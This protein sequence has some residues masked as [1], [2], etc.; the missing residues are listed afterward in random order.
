MALTAQAVL[1]DDRPAVVGA[2]ELW[3]APVVLLFCG[4]L[5]LHAVAP[6]RDDAR[7]GDA[8]HPQAEAVAR[9]AAQRRRVAVLRPD[10]DGHGR[11]KCTT[12]TRVEI[13]GRGKTADEDDGVERRVADLGNLR[14]EEVEDLL[15]GSV[16]QSVSGSSR[17][18]R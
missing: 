11:A 10:N 5:A 7:H 13:L 9:R 17:T 8:A 3:P 12:D 2:D 1:A 4:Q 6:R 16:E 18:G 14:R 15:C